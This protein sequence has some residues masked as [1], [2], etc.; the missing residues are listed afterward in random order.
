MGFFFLLL[1]DIFCLVGFVPQNRKLI[2]GFLRKR[3]AK[4]A[5]CCPQQA[6]RKDKRLWLHVKAEQKTSF[7][8]YS[9]AKVGAEQLLR[10]TCNGVWCKKKPRDMFS[11][12]QKRE[13]RQGSIQ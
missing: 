11:G 13:T 1:F 9:K 10:K 7:S 8:C 6:G 12:R 2:N 5:Y 3:R 4:V